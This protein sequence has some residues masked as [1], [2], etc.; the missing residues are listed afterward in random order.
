ML[1]EQVSNS[2][3]GFVKSLSSVYL[4]ITDRQKQIQ[5]LIWKIY[6]LLNLKFYLKKTSQKVNQKCSFAV[7]ISK[8]KN[9][10]KMNILKNKSRGKEIWGNANFHKTK[11]AFYHIPGII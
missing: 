11:M 4:N 9:K 3:D 7:T 6:G 2:V 10:K 8:T 5:Q 1:W